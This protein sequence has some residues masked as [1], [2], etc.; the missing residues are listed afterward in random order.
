MCTQGSKY[1]MFSREAID[2][3]FYVLSPRFYM[4]IVKFK[5]LKQGKLTHT[6]QPPHRHTGTLLDPTHD[7]FAVYGHISLNVVLKKK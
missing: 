5:I 1:S 7:I 2:L 4:L 6:P 3:N